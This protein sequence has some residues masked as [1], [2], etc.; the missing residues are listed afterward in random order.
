MSV[1]DRHLTVHLQIEIVK[2]MRMRRRYASSYQNSFERLSRF[3][4]ISEGTYLFDGLQ[5]IISKACCA[6]CFQ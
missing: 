2:P 3:V 6:S 5:A 1:H 4:R